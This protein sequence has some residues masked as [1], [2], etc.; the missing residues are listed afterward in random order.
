MEWW[1][2]LAKMR[3]KKD[4]WDWNQRADE[5]IHFSKECSAFKRGEEVFKS[6]VNKRKWL[7]KCH[8]ITMKGSI[9]K[10]SGKAS[11][12]YNCLFVCLLLFLSYSFKAAPP[13]WFYLT[14][15]IYF[16][17]FGNH[18]FKSYFWISVQELFKAVVR[19]PFEMLG[20]ENKITACKASTLC[21]LYY[22]SE[23][24]CLVFK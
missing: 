20:K 2:W 16:Y 11:K 9:G 12:K 14:L 13:T 22:H 3:V 21:P 4:I 17:W 18:I 10:A 1:E 23:P 24:R 8:I 15:L 19:G 7:R 6:S 5:P